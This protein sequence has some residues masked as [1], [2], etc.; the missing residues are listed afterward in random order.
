MTHKDIRR[1]KKVGNRMRETEE[2]GKK[3]S[4]D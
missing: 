4:N 3:K 2:K 1:G